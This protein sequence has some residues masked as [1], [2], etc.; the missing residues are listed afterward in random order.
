METTLVDTLPTNVT[1]ISATVSQGICSNAPGKVSCW[2]GA[3]DAGQTATL[4]VLVQPK[5]GG[6]ITNVATAIAN[7]YDTNLADNIAAD[8]VYVGYV[9]SPDA[10]REISFPN[11]DIVYVPNSG[12]IYAS[13]P[14]TGTYL[15]NCV[16][17][18]D[19]N[20]GVCDEPINAGPDPRKLVRSN[21]G[22]FIYASIMTNQQI[23]RIDVAS[24]TTNFQ[25][26]LGVGST[27]S[28]MDMEVLPAED[29]SVAVLRADTSC[30]VDLAVFDDGILR[31]NTGTVLWDC[32]SKNLK[33]GDPPLAFVQDM[34]VQGFSKYSIGPGG[35]TLAGSSPDLMGSWSMEWGNGVLFT[36][37]GAVID[38]AAGLVIGNIPS[39]TSLSLLTYDP[40]VRRIYYLT[41]D[42]ST[43]VVRA[44]DPDTLSVL[45]TLT[46]TNISGGPSRLVRWGSNGLAFRTDAD[47]LYILR[48]SLIPTNVPADLSV[49]LVSSDVSAIAGSD[50]TFSL[51]VS[52]LGPSVAS[53]VSVTAA[54]PPGTTID[55]A[56]PTQGGWTAAVS[57]QLTWTVGSLTNGAKASI[58]CV[59][60]PA[61]PGLL[62]F[63]AVVDGLVTDS[64][65]ANNHATWLVWTEGATTNDTLAVT[66][67][68]VNDVAIDPISGRLYLSLCS[69]S[70][71]APNSVLWINPSTKQ[72][73][74]PVS[75][76]GNPD[77][78]AVTADG[79]SL[80]VGLD[81]A[82]SVLRF[83]LPSQR[84]QAQ[85][86]FGTYGIALDI[87]PVP[88]NADQV[89][90]YQSAGTTA[91]FDN[92]LGLPSTL[93]DLNLFAF[94]DQT[95][96]LYA[97]GNYYCCQ[98]L[99]RLDLT[100]IGLAA[101]PGQIV[102]PQPTAAM[103][104][105]DGKLFFND[106]L[107]VDP[108]LNSVVGVFPV[109]Y[110]SPVE[111]DR[112]SG[113]T[114]FLTHSTNWVIKAFDVKQFAEVGSWPV[115]GITGTPRRL[116][117]WGVNGMAINTSSGQLILV[118]N[119]G[120]PL[121]G[122]ADL[123]VTQS[124][125][126]GSLSTN[127]SFQISL[128]LSNAGPQLASGVVVTQSFSFPIAN[129]SMSANV[130]SALFRSNQV[131]WCPGSLSTGQSCV[132]KFS[133]RSTRT[134]TL[135]V[136]AIATHSGN[137]PF[138]GN[139]V[140]ITPVQV[141]GSTNA[142]ALQLRLP[143]RQMIYDRVRDLLYATVPGSNGFLGNVIARISP[144]SG[145][146]TGS[147][148]VGSEP[149]R[150]ALSDDNRFLYVSLNGRMSVRRMD[151]TGQL[152][153]LE[154]P[155]VIGSAYNAFDIKTQPGCPEGLAASIAS[156]NGTMDYPETVAFYDHG[157]PR[158]QTSGVT[159]LTKPIVFSP[160]GRT[161]Y[162]SITFGVGYGFVRLSVNDQGITTIDSMFSYGGDNDLVLANGLVYGDSGHVF[163][164]NLPLLLTNLP[165]SGPVATDD[166]SVFYLVQVGTNWQ[167]RAYQLG[168]FAS[169]GTNTIAGVQG[170]PYG[171]LR[172]G[173]DRIAF[174]TTSNQLF[175]IPTSLASTTPS[176]TADIGVSQ[177]VTQDFLAQTLSFD[178][179]LTN[180]GLETASNVLL[181]IRPPT[182]ATN[183]SLV[184]SQ[185]SSQTVASNLVCQLGSIS[186]GTS[187]QLA[188][189]VGITNTMWFTNFVSVTTSTAET[190]LLNNVS[191][192]IVQGVWY[193]RSDSVR[194]T[195]ASVRDLAYDPASGWLYAIAKTNQLMWFDV[196]TGLLQGNMA[197][198]GVPN[199]LAISDQGSY[200]YI[201][202]IN[203]SR[204]ERVYLPATNVDLS[205]NVP[206]VYGP[207]AMTVLPSNP[208]ALA[209]SY[210]SNYV[211][212]TG[213]FDDGLERSNVDFR[214]YPVGPF[215]RLVCAPDGA[216]LFGL[217]AST[218]GASPDLF[219]MAISASGLQL[220]DWG[221]WDQPG[222]D[223]NIFYAP[224]RLVCG[225]GVVI[226]PTNWLVDAAYPLGSS[227]VDVAGIAALDRVAFLVSQTANYNN[228]SIQ[229][230]P[231]SSRLKLADINLQCIGASD[232]TACGADRFAAHTDSQILFIRS[233]AVPSADLALLA[234]ASTSA[235][236]V[237]DI[238]TFSLSV[239]NA[240]PSAVASA[241]L[242]ND[243]PAG[244]AFVSATTSQGSIST[245]GNELISVIGSLA[246]GT[247]AS[248]TVQAQATNA[249]VFTVNAVAANAGLPEDALQYN[250]SAALTVSVLP[251]DQ[252]PFP[253]PVLVTPRFS[254]NGVF[255][256]ELFGVIGKTYAIEWSTDLVQ[257]WPL[258]TFI[259]QES[260][261]R[262][263]V[264]IMA[265]PNCFYRLALTSK[266]VVAVLRL[267]NIPAP[268]ANPARLLVIAPPG[269]R[270][271]V[272]V[273]TNLK[274]WLELTNFLG[275]SFTNFFV[276]PDPSSFSARFYRVQTQ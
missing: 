42:G 18:I 144:G 127:D 235:C 236:Y 155:L 256:F 94:S 134:G 191:T 111:P 81:D 74:Q 63:S 146:V 121:T 106:G 97:C 48:T 175:I 189:T 231:L 62:N 2:F 232:L 263:Q 220:L 160:D 156:L 261:Q 50:Y 266:P 212:W 40:V 132:L 205:F 27:Y 182:P 71:V 31:S 4:T 6:W 51:V 264:P 224:G 190:N 215:T 140:A 245:N 139:N 84:P 99:T 172:C 136:S 109:S 203:T 192:A 23:A 196:E 257:W 55:F 57:D 34:G 82:S 89:I 114:F 221:P 253:A 274:D 238:V 21:S 8:S 68:G 14:A 259:C 85:F 22:Q 162:G 141:L 166:T 202:Y 47:R 218:T 70:S 208:H 135:Q 1:F 95:L 113:R 199:K 53:G 211:A 246:A 230:Y 58:T 52:N 195:A 65:N 125:S 233:S 75:I 105:S 184:Q 170:T 16:V 183:L 269:Y 153:D 250:N 198:S 176:P 242:T 275:S 44:I 123:S 69:A 11:A 244:L 116:I 270:Y 24:A 194:S 163:D 59:V 260:G 67:L 174:N 80:Y 77:R 219:R 178:I 197:L 213:I 234:A 96:Q 265:V 251:P 227:G 130:G 223:V 200:L 148:F 239:S 154:F 30:D 124:V 79:A 117:R 133:G 119:V 110:G 193:Q 13:I 247:A 168:T 7:Q 177:S 49:S 108:T 240:G 28:V 90:V 222:Y 12:R 181:I 83:N 171:L 15:S 137:D 10:V 5:L 122:N 45:G 237:G 249:G 268:P 88:T 104:F 157:V 187:L 255:E 37:S 107:V 78:L 120:L 161:I 185:G 91:L 138:W 226:S 25:F 214:A 204:V 39:I 32:Y 43:C 101:E 19:P 258:T 61:S 159:G 54:L 216:T 131:T 112:A 167:L 145:S 164:P 33:L 92:G 207:T 267:E 143:V 118:R 98:P 36:S 179:T 225:N 254:S 229:I 64:T 272:Q 228:C 241:Y 173:S 165:S 271:S 73:G 56:V 147:T 151:L 76:S 169:R 102:I 3:L 252:R 142:P 87:V 180:S 9:P 188:L 149:N 128:T 248:V 262:V 35:V 46:L 60:R 150:L 152:T 201:S 129:P 17:P 209:V 72:I 243:L 206:G 20:T 86:R 29:H 100:A 103:K 115:A 41:P 158:P 66:N 126:P 276:D 38:P 26:S 217:D 93:P 273:S 210:A 186:A